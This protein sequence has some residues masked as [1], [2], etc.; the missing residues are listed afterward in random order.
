MRQILLS[1]GKFPRKETRIKICIQEVYS[2]VHLSVI[3]CG[4]EAS[5]VGQREPDILLP[6]SRL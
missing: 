6:V 5:S 1:L 3:L 4:G 2:G